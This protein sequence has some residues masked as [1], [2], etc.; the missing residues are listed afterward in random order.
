MQSWPPGCGGLALPEKLQ[1]ESQRFYFRVRFLRPPPRTPPSYS[2]GADIDT[3]GNYNSVTRY[4]TSSSLSVNRS[5]TFARA[6]K[7]TAL[8]SGHPP[9][10]SLRSPSTTQLAPSTKAGFRNI[11]LLHLRPNAR[12]TVV[13]TQFVFLLHACARAGCREVGII[14]LVL[15]VLGC[16]CVRVCCSCVFILAASDLARSAGVCARASVCAPCLSCLQSWPP[17]SWP[18]RG[19]PFCSSRS[20]GQINSGDHLVCLSRCVHVALSCS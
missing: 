16:A 20:R 14:Q 3:Q 9:N 19:L 13:I 2:A 6:Q 17:A 15:L 4:S 1:K 11:P 10:Y 18:L 8:K 12:S 7:F 5:I